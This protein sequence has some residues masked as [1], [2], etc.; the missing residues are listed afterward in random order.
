MDARLLWNHLLLQLEQVSYWTYSYD[1]NLQVDGRESNSADENLYDKCKDVGSF[2]DLKVN[3]Y[4]IWIGFKNWLITYFHSWGSEK[5]W[6][7]DAYIYTAESDSL[8]SSYFGKGWEFSSNL[9]CFSYCNFLRI[10]QPNPSDGVG[11]SEC[12]EYWPGELLDQLNSITPW[13]THRM[14]LSEYSARGSSGTASCSF[15]W[16]TVR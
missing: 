15:P 10:G 12:G 2:K 14:K 11:G 7:N 4:K 16:G 8:F 3:I 13:F 1:L 9:I 5:S 6:T